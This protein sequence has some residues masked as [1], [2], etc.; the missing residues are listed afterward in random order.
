MK[1]SSQ[2]GERVRKNG[3]TKYQKWKRKQNEKL[4]KEWRVK[5][6][7]NWNKKVSENVQLEK[8]RQKV[9]R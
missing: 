9:E 1:K 6:R 3:V 5:C 4:E 2:K 8:R 7:E